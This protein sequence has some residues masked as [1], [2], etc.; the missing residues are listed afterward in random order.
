MITSLHKRLAYLLTIT[1]AGYDMKPCSSSTSTADGF[2][3]CSSRPSE[4][5]TRIT[6]WFESQV[7]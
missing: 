4:E 5:S 2:R 3:P 1:T 7:R 6:P